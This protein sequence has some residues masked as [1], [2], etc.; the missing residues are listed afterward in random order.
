MP[1]AN[2]HSCDQHIDTDVFVVIEKNE[3]TYDFVTI[4]ESASFDAIVIDMS[5][6]DIANAVIVDFDADDPADSFVTVDEE[7]DQVFISDFTADD[8]LFDF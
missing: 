5:Q 2:I 8:L 6:N 7:E 3:D 4:D 1:E